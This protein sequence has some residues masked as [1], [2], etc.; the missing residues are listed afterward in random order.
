MAAAK[1]PLPFPGQFHAKTIG[2]IFS[3]P[4]LAEEMPETM[5]P[6]INPGLASPDLAARQ[7]MLQRKTQGPNIFAAQ[8]IVLKSSL[9]AVDLCLCFLSQDFLLDVHMC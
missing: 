8:K 2:L 9:K 4:S 5:P 3:P 6:E 7:L 1:Q